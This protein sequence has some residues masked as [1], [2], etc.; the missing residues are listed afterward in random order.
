MKVS[1]IVVVTSP[2][3]KAVGT[4]GFIYKKHG[5]DYF[6]VMF[7][8]GKKISYTSSGIDGISRDSDG[9]DVSEYEAVVRSREAYYDTPTG[10]L[11]YTETERK[12]EERQRTASS[13]TPPL[14]TERPTSG[15]LAEATSPSSEDIR[16][17]TLALQ[18]LFIQLQTINK[19]TEDGFAHINSRLS[20]MEG[21]LTVVERDDSRFPEPIPDMSDSSN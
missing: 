12:R 13:S 11:F 18:E 10:R 1:D 16:K 9:V 15:G 2:R 14:P 20:D 4:Y 5:S 19:K 21:R 3:S 6:G 8:S 7:P 17:L